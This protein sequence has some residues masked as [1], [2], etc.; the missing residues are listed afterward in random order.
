[1][2]AGLGKDLF[3]ALRVFGKI[4]VLAGCWTE[5][6]SF[7]LAVGQRPPSV[8]CL[9]GLPNMAACITEASKG[10]NLPAR[11]KLKHSGT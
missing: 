5:G 11:G 9:E 7:L 3:Q 2:E 10:Q 8:S 6:L 1:M 4:D